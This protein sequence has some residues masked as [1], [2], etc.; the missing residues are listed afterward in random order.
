MTN[1]M[2][3]NETRRRQ[4][5]LEDLISEKRNQEEYLLMQKMVEQ[6]EA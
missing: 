4:E 1:T 6:R 2:N 3:I 5:I